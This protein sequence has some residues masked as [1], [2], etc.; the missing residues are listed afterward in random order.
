MNFSDVRTIGLGTGSEL[1][2][3]A[4]R[5][6]FP[7][8]T[9]VPVG[10]APSGVRPQPIGKEET[11]TGARNRA[12]AARAAVPDAQAWIGIEN[13][14]WPGEDQT[15]ASSGS[16][17][18]DAACIAVFFADGTECHIWSDELLIPDG[19]LPF[20]PGPNGEWSILKDPH[21]V[22]TNGARPR[23][24]FIADALRSALA[25]DERAASSPSGGS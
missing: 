20:P 15:T 25:R 18:V 5:E 8:V 4:V 12:A 2:I 22:L 9:V 21:S 7:G 14:M 17:R 19:E 23:Q 1:K 3:A 10:D 24:K 6:V 13:G 11:A 16:S